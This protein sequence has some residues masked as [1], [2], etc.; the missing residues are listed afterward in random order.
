MYK[1]LKCNKIKVT[2]LLQ[3]IG[4]M[5]VPRPTSRVEI[6]AA[7]RRVR[8]SMLMTL[9]YVHITH[10]FQK[11]VH[12]ENGEQSTFRASRPNLNSTFSF[13]KLISF[14]QTNFLYK[15]EKCHDALLYLAIVFFDRI[16]ISLKKLSS[17][18][19]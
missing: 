16:R 15:D 12:S 8:V 6:V 1:I 19:L 5:D 13:T 11:L 14:R 17:Y 4:T 2:F 10:T 3:Y 7:M 9:H 18:G